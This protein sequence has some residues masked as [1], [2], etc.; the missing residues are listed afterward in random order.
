MEKINKEHPDLDF[1]DLGTVSNNLTRYELGPSRRLP[2]EGRTIYE[3]IV[4]LFLND[5]GSD[6]ETKAVRKYWA[7]WVGEVPNYPLGNKWHIQPM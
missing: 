2:G 5:R 6:R 7:H 4:T 3:F 1:Y